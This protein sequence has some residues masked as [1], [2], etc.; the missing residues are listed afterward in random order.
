MQSTNSTNSAVSVGSSDTSVL[1][2]DAGRLGIILVNDSDEAIYLGFGTA[3]VMNKGV[4]LNSA[5]GSLVL[6]NALMTSQAINAI[7]TSGSKVL[8]YTTFNQ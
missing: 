7:C 6:D 1:T 3:A 5:G 4:R 2:A 8:T